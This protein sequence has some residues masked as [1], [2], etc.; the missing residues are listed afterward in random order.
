MFRRYGFKLLAV[1][2]FI[3]VA[4]FGRQVCRIIIFA[5]KADVT[6]KPFERNIPGARLK[7]L[8]FGDSTAVGTGS[9]SNSQSVA[10]RF[11][12]DFP[13]AEIVNISQNGKKIHGL[14][15]DFLPLVGGHYDLA[16]VQIGAND[17]M[18]LTPLSNIERDLSI[19]VENIKKSADH[20]VILHSG[21]VGLAPIFS[22]PF[23]QWLAARSRAVRA[24]YMKKAQELG[25]LYVDLFRERDDDLFLKDIPRYYAPDG[26]H[27][28]GDGYGWWYEK[29]RS[30][31]K[32]SNLE[33]S[34]L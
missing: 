6:V 18:W 19:V 34:A 12:R 26:L 5:K 22:W 28:G 17:I 16:V 13:Q 3:V 11:G 30:T 23:D 15:R 31:L 10:G 20:V 27:P 29:I 4:V 33:L 21:N 2:L 32:N 25:V 7:I 1:L 9:K 24:L 14:V 8:F